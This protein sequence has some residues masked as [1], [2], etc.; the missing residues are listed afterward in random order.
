MAE[1][2]EKATLGE[3]CTALICRGSRRGGWL[4]RRPAK[5]TVQIGSPKAVER[6]TDEKREILENCLKIAVF[7]SADSL[8]KSASASETF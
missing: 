2:P 3:T 8:S 5:R 7:N 4:G 6:R 1:R